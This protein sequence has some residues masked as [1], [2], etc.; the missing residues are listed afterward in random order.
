MVLTNHELY[1]FND[2]HKDDYDKMIILTPGVFVKSLPVTH[3]DKDSIQ[4]VKRIF[5]IELQIGDV[6]KTN[7]SSLTIGFET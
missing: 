5:P 1:L 7:H 6:S 4:T 2:R 3:F